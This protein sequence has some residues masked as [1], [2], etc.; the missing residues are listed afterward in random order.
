MRALTRVAELYCRRAE[1]K[2]ALEYA[3]KALD[4][5]MY[6][7]D[8]NFIYG[9]ISKR[10]DNL[11]DAKETLGWAARSMKYR[12]SAYSE[13]GSIYL[14]EGNLE[15]ALTYLNRALEYDANNI[16]TLQVLA[17]AYRAAGQAANATRIVDRIL[18][19][20]PLNHLARFERYLL[21]GAP[22]DLAEFK[23]LIRNEL[24]HETYL[25]IAVS[26][27]NRRRD[28]DALRVLDNAPEH[29]TVRYW[30]AYLLR[31]KDPGRSRQLLESAAALSPYLVFPFR[32]ESVPVFEWAVREKPGDW[33]A[34]Y[35]LGLVYWGLLRPDDARRSL[36]ACGDRP[37]YAPVYI[38]RAYLN[39]ETDPAR[40]LADYERAHAVGK[41]DWRNWY[42]LATYYG[43]RE[44]AR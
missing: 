4:Y 19:I 8:A 30:Q 7:P 22:S 26:Y 15:R 34:K 17:N 6:D 13:L 44:Y 10:L 2:K 24:P 32:E 9:I 3:R 42:H 29:P 12:A 41:S 35:Y 20:D 36:E 16:S 43:T 25:E 18:E 40:A 5:V 14:M 1:Y 11:V 28:A 33:K 37:D 31:A 27:A 39:R 38:S 23:S 21:S